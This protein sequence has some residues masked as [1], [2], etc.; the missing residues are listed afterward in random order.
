MFS[1]EIDTFSPPDQLH[2]S[3]IP[4]DPSQIQLTEVSNL[5]VSLHALVLLAQELRVL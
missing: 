1:T 3:V 4:N 2:G 5:Q